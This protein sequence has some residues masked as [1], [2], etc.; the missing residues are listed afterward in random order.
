ML[1][2]SRHLDLAAETLGAKGRGQL[3]VQDLECDR[4]VVLRVLR[5]KD[6]GHAATPQLALQGVLSTERRLELVPHVR[7]RQWSATEVG[8]LEATAAPCIGLAR[9]RSLDHGFD[10]ALMVCAAFAA[11]GVLTALVRGR[12]G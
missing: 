7:R 8:V 6:R 11:A 10:T 5:K 3:G 1:E 4:A 12:Q 9:W 2:P